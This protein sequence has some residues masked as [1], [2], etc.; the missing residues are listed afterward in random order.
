MKFGLNPFSLVIGKFLIVFWK[1]MKKFGP[2]EEILENF[3]FYMFF[4]SMGEKLGISKKNNHNESH[5]LIFKGFVGLDLVEK[6]ICLMY[7]IRGCVVV[8][9]TYLNLKRGTC[10]M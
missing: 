6:M 7:S 8:L 10:Y 9:V 2:F 5:A 3:G 1:I 4:G